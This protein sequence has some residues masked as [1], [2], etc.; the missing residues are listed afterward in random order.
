M[1]I[2]CLWS[3]S[4]SSSCSS[5]LSNLSHWLILYSWSTWLFSQP[6]VNIWF[7]VSTCPSFESTDLQEFI[8]IITYQRF[9]RSLFQLVC[10]WLVPLWVRVYQRPALNLHVYVMFD[11][12]NE[13]PSA[14]YNRV[15]C[16]YSNDYSF[17]Y[18][19][20]AA[21][22]YLPVISAWCVYDDSFESDDIFIYTALMVW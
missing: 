2:L 19:I 15:N 12:S 6:V 18:Q 7:T 14:Y 4:S 17:S 8:L 22:S 16:V 9:A 1:K 13:V 21:T 11:L 10:I 3:S 20:P 5:F